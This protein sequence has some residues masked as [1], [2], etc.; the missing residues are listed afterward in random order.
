[1]DADPIKIMC[2]YS[3]LDCPE[4]S[5]EQAL[6]ERRYCSRGMIILRMCPCGYKMGR[7]QKSSGE[8]G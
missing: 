5:V 1:V 3:F 7:S 6:L 2:I 8:Y 4:M